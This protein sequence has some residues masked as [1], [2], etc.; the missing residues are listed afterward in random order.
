METNDNTNGEP[1]VPSGY[2]PLQPLGKHGKHGRDASRDRAKVP[3]SQSPSGSPLDAGAVQPAST[4]RMSAAQPASTS[5]MAT[6]PPPS[7]SSTGS[8]PLGHAGAGANADAGF[9]QGRFDMPGSH[10]SPTSRKPFIIVG[11][12][13]ALLLAI[14]VGVA[15]YFTF[16][17]MP[18]TK[19]GESDVSLMSATDAE[20]AVAQVVGAYQ[21]SLQ[22]QGLEVKLKGSDLSSS[23]SATDVAREAM[24]A[25]S[26]WVWPLELAQQHDETE[27]LSVAFSDLKAKDAVREAV[28]AHNA[29]AVGPVD[30]AIAFDAAKGAYAVTPEQIGTKLEADAV[31]DAAWKAVSS[32]SPSLTVGD[33]FLQKPVVTSDDA[34]LVAAVDTANAMAG[35][36]FALTMGKDTAAKVDASLIS[37]WIK[38]GDD[39]SVTFDEAALAAWANDLAKACTTVGTTRAYTRPDGKQI[40]VSGGV[41]GWEVKTDELVAQVKEGVT[42]A[43]T[44]PLEVPCGAKGDAYHGAGKQDWGNRY[45]DVDLSE[46]HARFYDESGAIIWESDIITGIPDGQHDTPAGV[47]WVNRKASPSTLSGY[48]G[49]ANIY[50][51]EVQYWMPFVGDAVGFHDADWQSAFG[52]TLYKDGAGSHGCVNL[53]PAKAQELYSLLVEADTIVCHW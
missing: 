16:H 19:I 27:K 46:Q 44:D 24:A 35:A 26:P 20:G 51:T 48:Q 17:F 38:L 28:N 7:P 9:S 25:A 14:Y 49:D 8:I 4:S 50:N 30:A 45:L 42:A 21:F 13:V 43:R 6:V 2:R 11:V 5:R 39:F 31:V 37:Q 15:V 22:G 18:N 52:G 29:S 40:T 3:G 34:R 53:P 32:L 33:D 12:V 23:Q 41:Y 1:E 10:K 47:Y 36:N